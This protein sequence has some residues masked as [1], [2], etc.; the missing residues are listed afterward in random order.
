MPNA[1]LADRTRPAGGKPPAFFFVWAL[2]TGLILFILMDNTRPP[3]DQVMVRI[4]V[5]FI[6]GYKSGLS[7]PLGKA[8]INPCRFEPTCSRYAREALLKYGFLEGSRL[9]CWRVLRCNPFYG[10]PP[11][12]DPVP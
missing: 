8:G 6:D 9:A 2:V 3:V 10:D 1:G 12:H 7:R 4:S 5:G 11:I